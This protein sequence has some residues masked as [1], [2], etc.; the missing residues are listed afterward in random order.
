[1]RR[2]IIGGLMAVAFLAGLSACKP[3][4]LRADPKVEAVALA[5]YEDIATGRADKVQSRLTPEAAKVTTPAQILSLRPYADAAKPTARRLI[6][7]NIFKNAKGPEAQ[8]LVYELVYP[9]HAILYTVGLQRPNSAGTWSIQSLNLN[10]ATD[11]QLA[12]SRLTLIGRSPAQLLF[13]AATILSPALM[14]CTVVT[15][16]RAP[17]LKRKWLWILLSL[18]GI[19]SARMN[20]TTGQAEFQPLSFLLIG[21]GITKQ[22][23][24]NFFPWVLKFTPPLGAIIALAH[25]SDALKKAKSKLDASAAQS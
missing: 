12:Q 10:R 2:K 21:F 25:A 13:L 6:S 22:G 16:L 1:M 14:L 11:A 5:T 20:W 8:T 3:V 19:G 9:G 4:E 18:A 17:G 24:S 15:V 7:I 23:L